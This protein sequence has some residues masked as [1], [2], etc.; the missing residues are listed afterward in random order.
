MKKS[1]NNERNSAIELL[2]IVCM[3]F[4]V[5][6]HCISQSVPI[7]NLRIS[8]QIVQIFMGGYARL[9]TACFMVI[10]I[11]YINVNDDG[12]KWVIKRLR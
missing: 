3:F 8:T 1:I 10:T 7:A 4:I 2:R 11:W 6:G 9:A 5:W 12:S